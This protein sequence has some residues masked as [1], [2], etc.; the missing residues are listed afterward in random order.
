MLFAETNVFPS[1]AS[2]QS[3]S[4]ESICI[5][6]TT[7]QSEYNYRTKSTHQFHISIS[8]YS[9]YAFQ[10]KRSNFEPVVHIHTHTHTRNSQHVVIEYQIC[11]G[12]LRGFSYLVGISLDQAR[13]CNPNQISVE[14]T[15]PTTLCGITN[16]RFSETALATLIAVS[17]VSLTNEQEEG[18]K[19]NNNNK[20]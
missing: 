15:T 17:R 6:T 8:Q 19:N 5:S 9:V 14:A 3:I 2:Q 20:S 12:P 16:C 13:E 11:V 1:R 7:D 4:N 18:K 10:S